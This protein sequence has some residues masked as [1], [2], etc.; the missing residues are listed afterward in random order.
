MGAVPPKWLVGPA[1]EEFNR[2]APQMVALGVL[3][4]WDRGLF[5]AWCETWG[6]YVTLARQV[7]E[8]GEIITEV[9]ERGHKQVSPEIS[10]LRKCLDDM[11]K[12]AARFGFSPS[13]RTRIDIQVPRGG[14]DDDWVL[15]ISPNRFR[16]L[17]AIS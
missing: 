5:V 6:R 8:S 9:G 7:S 1:L 13:D 17:R 4:D 10:E 15:G 3:T 12:L 14:S 2:L 11:V 16:T